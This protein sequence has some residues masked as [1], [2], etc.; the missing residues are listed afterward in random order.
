VGGVI[1]KP[2]VMCRGEVGPEDRE[3]ESV[4]NGKCFLDCGVE[5]SW[6]FCS[7]ILGLWFC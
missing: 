5:T 1:A 4:E 3:D 6:P 7:K 2:N